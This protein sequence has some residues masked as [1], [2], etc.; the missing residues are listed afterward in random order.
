MA[1]GEFD[2]FLHLAEG[3]RLELTEEKPR[4]KPEFPIYRHAVQG[5]LDAAI[6]KAG[7]LGVE[8]K[9]NVLFE[10]QFIDRIRSVYGF[11]VSPEFT[12]FRYQVSE[13]FCE[14]HLRK[15]NEDYE[16]FRD[17]SKAFLEEHRK[18]YQF[19]M[20]RQHVISE[21]R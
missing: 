14:R 16:K 8:L 11:V 19:A 15:T 6:E 9:E 7:E 2:F 3:I 12:K 17:I 13:K 21:K 1:Y 18:R 4:E 10:H 5:G 20:S